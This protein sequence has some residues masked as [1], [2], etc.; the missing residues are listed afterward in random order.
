MGVR[1]RLADVIKRF[2]TSIPADIQ[3]GEQAA[4]MGPVKPFSPGEP[5]GPYDGFS[6]TP[7]THDFVPGYNIA[8]RP[9]THERVAFE[10]LRG[11]V[12]AYDVA[13][14]C[15]WHR[16]DSIRS[17][18]WS[19]IAKNG[20]GGDVTDAIPVGMK[21]LSKP[22]GDQPFATW[23]ASWLYDIL[24]Y[25]AG[26]LYRM[27]N[28]AGRTIG[29][30]VVDGTTI[31]PLL[32]YWGNPP[33]DPAEAFVQYANG[34]PWNW[35]TRSDLIYLPFRKRPNSI[36]GTAPLESILLNA[37]TDLRFQAYF[38]QRFT[39]GNIPEAFAS[40]PE[41]WTPQQIELFQEHW[42][43][44]LMGDQAAKHQIRWL[45]AG[46]AIQWSNEKDF[47]D[48]FSMFLMRKTAA[49]YHVVPA[50]LGFTENVNR[51][52]G[53]SQADV[54]H[55]VGDLPLIRH[56]QGILSSFLQDDLGLPLDFA[57]DLGEEQADR[58]Q[59]AQ[60]DEI[61]V[62]LGAISA[63]DVREL[64]YGLPEPDGIP[65]PRYVYTTRSGPIPLA[66]LYGVA[67]QIDPSTA[68][69]EPGAPLPH[70]VFTGVEGTQP[71][72]PIPGVPLA[73]Q[74]YGPSA[75]P[76]GAQPVEKDAAPAAPTTGITSET[77]ITGYDL[78]GHHQ[79]DEEEDDEDEQLVKAELAAF[80]NFRKARRRDRRWR[81]F[82]F[83]HVPPAQAQQLNAE[84][85]DAVHKATHPKAD[86][87]DTGASQDW[88]G[89][90]LDERC[91]NH[92]A[93]LIAAALAAALT[94]R[95]A[96]EIARDYQPPDSSDKKILTAAALSWL[97]VQGLDL[98]TPLHDTLTGLYTDAYL[99]GL[100]AA[101]AKVDRSSPDLGDW[102]PGDTDKARSRIAQLGATA[103]LALL[104]AGIDEIAASIAGTRLKDM[105]K[106]LVD[107]TTAGDTAADTGAALQDTLGDPDRAAGAAITEV[108][109]G[110]GAGALD[111]YQQRQI[112]M[113]RWAI[114][115]GSKV[116]PACLG[117][118]AA[119]RVPLGQPYPSGDTQPPVHPHCRCAVVPA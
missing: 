58:L 28:R 82:E 40:A 115:P 112:N 76:A 109:R 77:G 19:L 86:A 9:R 21:I 36:Y 50:D 108:T 96:K 70:T 94:T 7:R 65:V 53:E 45:P 10:T 4:G 13:Q 2:G 114:D 37:N 3:A 102:Q 12:E 51:S 113:G 118:A 110:S 29:L 57:F 8:T 20:Y 64:R 75:L 105:A 91:A 119:G 44:L 31:A 23:L 30:R 60:A 74:M 52:S 79:D 107:S 73:E 72:P 71:T 100:T 99:I 1:S 17:L 39:E 68:A 98:E 14:M 35:L 66:S 61:Y 33:A 41:S 27:R 103:G 5:I 83:R 55:R 43:A 85:R 81:D 104:L 69:P 93:P 62:N 16:I 15:I 67:G 97:A 25:D 116:C 59:Q 89:W 87:P 22:D 46:S 49:A 78:V 18:D 92:W 42:D 56:V 6:R 80:R 26:T 32:D 63:S 88:P 24:A 48:A 95:Q 54:Q 117:N 47:T 106:A 101:L 38:L 11:L 34:L 111:G 90:Q 84:G